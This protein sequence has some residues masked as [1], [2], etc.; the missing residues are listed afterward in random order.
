MSERGREKKSIVKSLYREKFPTKLAEYSEREGG[1]LAAK[2][3]LGR[4]W[5]KIRRLANSS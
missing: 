1:S 2:H 4:R 3:G 5:Q